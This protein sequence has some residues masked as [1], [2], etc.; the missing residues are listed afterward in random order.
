MHMIATIFIILQVVCLAILS[1]AIAGVN[2]SH[3]IETVR[4]IFI[5]IIVLMCFTM[6]G[7]VSF[8]ILIEQCIMQEKVGCS[9]QLISDSR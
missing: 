4:A 2:F 3:R 1:L 6:A 8:K 9:M 5:I 7:M